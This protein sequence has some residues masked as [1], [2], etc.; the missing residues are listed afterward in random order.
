MNPKE[1]YPLLPPGL[2]LMPTGVPVPTDILPNME[3]KA[4]HIWSCNS[5]TH[6]LLQAFYS[7][8]KSSYFPRHEEKCPISIPWLITHSSIPWIPQASFMLQTYKNLTRG[9]PV[10]ISLL[11]NSLLKTSTVKITPFLLYI[12][13]F[14]QV[15]CPSPATPTTPE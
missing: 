3:F 4:S 11:P 12:S 2:Y 6:I 13:T 9:T 5:F 10:L 7:T 14:H 8:C 1:A 15:S